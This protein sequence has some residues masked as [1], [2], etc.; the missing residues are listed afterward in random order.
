M[1]AEAYEENCPPTRFPRC[2]RRTGLIIVNKR[3]SRALTA[4]DPGRVRSPCLILLLQ[5]P[6]N[7]KNGIEGLG[8]GTRIV[9][10][11][12]TPPL[13]VI[14][15][16]NPEITV[17]KLGHLCNTHF[18][19][20]ELIQ[21]N[22]STYVASGYFQLC[23]DIDEHIDHV[24]KVMEQLRGKELLIAIDAN[25]RST[26]WGAQKTNTKGE[27][28]E[29]LFAQWGLQ[30]VNEGDMATIS[31]EI[32]EGH[33]DVTLATPKM[34]E[35]I[36][37]WK[38]RDGWTS[39]D[40]RAITFTIKTSKNVKIVNTQSS[41]SCKGYVTS[42]AEWNFVTERLMQEWHSK[43]Y[44]DLTNRTQVIDQV[45][46]VS[47]ALRKAC[48]TSIPIRNSRARKVPWWNPELTRLKKVAYRA[49]RK[50]QRNKDPTKR[51]QKLEEYRREKWIYH[52]CGI[53]KTTLPGYGFRKPRMAY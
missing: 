14:A 50:L 32:G 3:S 42:K 19:I 31:S 39:S 33:P 51:A 20:A 4:L 40:H 8:M 28:L 43:P 38:V 53:M 25:A 7:N 27:K 9:K 34:Y 24:Q 44:N 16:I 11:G 41:D 46:H 17:T 10:H 5:E 6:Y 30:V 35:N 22:K 15:V 23:H 12:N 48:N 21:S 2:V 52:Q 26:L 29:A 13:A 37:G 1:R 47:K 45:K 36:S 49:R 18:V